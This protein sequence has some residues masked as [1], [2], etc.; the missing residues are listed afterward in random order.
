MKAY[1]GDAK[2]IILLVLSHVA[3][4]HVSTPFRR[5]SQR[6]P[7]KW[8]P[9]FRQLPNRGHGQSGK[10]SRTVFICER[11]RMFNTS[12][13]SWTSKSS[14]KNIHCTSSGW[15]FPC[16]ALYLSHNSSM[17][18]IIVIPVIAATQGIQHK[19]P[20]P[21]LPSYLESCFLIVRQIIPKWPNYSGERN[22]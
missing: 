2:L 4:Q 22:I 6:T 5:L 14:N 21:V 20:K 17:S 16:V 1:T 15:A 10:R 8:S 7:T 9:P 19:E 13:W 3:S 18:I 12:F 11:R